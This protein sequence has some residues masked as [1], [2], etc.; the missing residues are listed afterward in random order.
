[1]DNRLYATTAQ[2]WLHEAEF[3]DEGQLSWKRAIVLAGPDGKGEAHATGIAV[4]ADGKTAWVCLS[5]NNSLG[6]VDLARGKLLRELAVGVAPYAVVVTKDESTAFVSNWGGRRA[7]KGDKTA[8]S[9]GTP[10]VI[11]ERGVAASGT[12]GKVG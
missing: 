2:R 7:R 11:D 5:R 6:V 10:A 3:D 8:D 4:S 1:R 12:V 9:S